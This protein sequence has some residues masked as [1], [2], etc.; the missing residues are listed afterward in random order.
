MIEKNQ[1]KT[2][3]TILLIISLGLFA[4]NQ[5]LDYIYKA[6]FLKNPCQLCMQ[7]NPDVQDCI[8]MKENIYFKN[9][10]S[11]DKPLTLD[12]N[13]TINYTE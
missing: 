13:I 7:L 3:I 2:A 4:L 10:L 12:Y 11:W 5:T 8:I 9:N 6:Q 1:L